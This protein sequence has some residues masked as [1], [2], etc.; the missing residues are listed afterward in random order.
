MSSLRPRKKAR[1]ARSICV[2]VAAPLPPLTSLPLAVL[3]HLLT[4]LPVTSLQLLAS[5]CT[6][7]HQLIHGRTITNLEFPFTPAFLQELQRLENQKYQY[8]AVQPVP[9]QHD[10]A[11]TGMFPAQVAPMPPMVPMGP[12]CLWGEV[13]YRWS[14]RPN[15][16]EV[17]GSLYIY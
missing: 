15:D 7:L 8:G 10:P 9:A 11:N 13:V 3:E 16:Y 1:R 14:Q 5:T 4:F 2:E 17:L 6:F 12:V